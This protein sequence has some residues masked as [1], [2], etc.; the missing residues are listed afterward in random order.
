MA[1]PS[2]SSSARSLRV[3]SL[4]TF[5][6]TVAVSVPGA[7]PST[8]SPRPVTVRVKVSSVS[9]ASGGMIVTCGVTLVLSSNDTLTPLTPLAGSV[10]AQE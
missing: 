2:P 9:A 10:S 7:M 4:V 8:T 6:I 5:T 1:L 3:A